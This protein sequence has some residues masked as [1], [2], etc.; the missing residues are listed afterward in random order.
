MHDITPEVVERDLPPEYLLLDLIALPLIT[1]KPLFLLLRVF[2]IIDSPALFILRLDLRIQFF[3][4][5]NEDFGRLLSQRL[6]QLSH[7]QPGILLSN[8]FKELFDDLGRTETS[9]VLLNRA[10][11]SL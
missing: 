10:L 8:Q 4:P 2:I 3:L 9:D 7:Q 5:G 1:V 11:M 6:R